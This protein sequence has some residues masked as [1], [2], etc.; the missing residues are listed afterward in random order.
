MISFPKLA[1]IA[2]HPNS[3]IKEFK[4]AW[5][6]NKANLTFSEIPWF[7]EN[8][9]NA[10]EKI[11]SP[12]HSV[13]EYGAGS[14][15]LYFA[16]YARKVNSVDSS[17]RYVAGVIS[18]AAR[19][20]LTNINLSVADIGVIRDWG[21]PIDHYPTKRNLR[22][23]AKYV[24]APWADVGNASVGLVVIDGRFR[25]AA[26]AYSIACLLERG[27]EDAVIFLDDFVGREDEYGILREIADLV[28]TGGR[29]VIVKPL[30]TDSIKAREFS[31]S[32]IHIVG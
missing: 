24:A 13:I 31:Q 29:G 18:E 19:R 10:I 27:E 16:R 23:W 12:K 5:G 28:T 17:R 25:V 30:I 2:S 22:K 1:W 4:T 7:D 6:L 9:L 11:L 15:T 3:A 20:E 21:W 32:W 14:S 8:D 26:T